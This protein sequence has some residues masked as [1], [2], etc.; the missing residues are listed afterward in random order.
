[1][2][3]SLDNCII[4]VKFLLHTNYLIKYQKEFLYVFVSFVV[5]LSCELCDLSCV[6]QV[7]VERTI[8][9]LLATCNRCNCRFSHNT[10]CIIQI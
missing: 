4:Y 3:S 7:L 8:Y 9:L 5:Y 1:M 2:K 10:Q 6:A